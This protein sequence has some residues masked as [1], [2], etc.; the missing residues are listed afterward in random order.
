MKITLKKYVPIFYAI[1]VLI[2]LFAPYAS[3]S[4]LGP[5]GMRKILQILVYFFAITNLIAVLI[6][7]LSKKKITLSQIMFLL[8]FAIYFIIRTFLIYDNSIQ[9]KGILKDTD[10]S[11]YEFLKGR[12]KQTFLSILI[13]L[14]F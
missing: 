10:I 13:V 3:D 6:S 2:V 14:F 8:S 4:T 12:I 11:Y 5:N 9:I 7:F 1:S